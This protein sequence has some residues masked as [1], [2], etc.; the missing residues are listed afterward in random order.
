MLSKAKDKLTPYSKDSRVGDLIQGQLPQI[1]FNDAC[2]D[3]VTFIQVLQHLDKP[4]EGFTNTKS[5]I[6]EAFRVLKP[7]GVLLIN[8]STHDQLRYGEWYR[9]LLPHSVENQCD[10]FIPVTELLA[11][12]KEQGFEKAAVIVCPWESILTDEQYFN[13]DGPFD[14]SWRKI[15]SVWK[16]AENEGELE[17]ALKTLKEKKDFG[18]FDDW[19]EQVEEKRK[20]LGLTTTIFVQKPQSGK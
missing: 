16:I 6:L 18:I 15:D 2:F 11:F 3:A 12:L 4:Y 7:G 1:A 19:F 17:A 20:N 9:N 13:M 5:S 14:E 10:R 8:T